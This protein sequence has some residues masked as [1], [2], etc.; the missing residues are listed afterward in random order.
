MDGAASK[1]SSVG[2]DRVTFGLAIVTVG[3]VALYIVAAVLHL[4]VRIPLGFATLAVPEPI[5]PATMVEALIAAGL[6]AAA[7]ATFRQSRRQPRLTRVAYVVA[8]I[9]TVFGL[10]IALLRGLRGLDIW[11]HLV[12]L[13]GLAGGFV[14]L[15]RQ[16]LE[17]RLRAT[18][19][20]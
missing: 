5:P 17:G 6:A 20:G 3:N 11:I 9:G 15:R 2:R 19:S 1:H 10:T 8:L 18:G 4:G 7:V 13:A 12:M 16:Q 14:L